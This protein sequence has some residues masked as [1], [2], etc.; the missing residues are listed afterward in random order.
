MPDDRSGLGCRAQ[1]R[2]T[3]DWPDTAA[4][5]GRVAVASGT[6]VAGGAVSVI[7]PRWFA[8]SLQADGH[9]ACRR[10]L[11]RL[12]AD[13]GLALEVL[14][15]TPRRRPPSPDRASAR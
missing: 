7:G 11:D 6:P 14:P 15:D 12:A 2:T 4:L 3:A 5:A 10:A 8:L 1:V 9:T 13:R